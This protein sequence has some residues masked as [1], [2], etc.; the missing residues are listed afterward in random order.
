MYLVIII[1]DIYNFLKDLFGGLSSI[2]NFIIDLF[3]KLIDIINYIIDFI[4]GLFSFIFS[5][6]D[7]LP[8][9]IKLLLSSV[10]TIVIAIAI[11]KV[12]KK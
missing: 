12:F 5:F 9:E 10:L 11:F 1:D 6:L 8:N 2:I 7:Y 3:N 4:G